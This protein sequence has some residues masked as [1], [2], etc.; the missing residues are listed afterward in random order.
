MLNDFVSSTELPWRPVYSQ[1]GSASPAEVTFDSLEYWIVAATVFFTVT[2]YVF[3]NYLNQRQLLAFEKTEFPKQLETTVDGIDKESAVAKKKDDDDSKKN[4]TKDDDAKK[5]NDD[6][7][8]PDRNAPL[9]PQLR[10][11]FAKAQSYGL[12]RI[13]FGMITDL[14]NLVE[15]VGFLLLGFLPYSWDL[16]ARIGRDNPVYQTESEIGVSLIFVL[17]TTLFGMVTSLPFELY[18]TFRIEKK[19]GFNKMTLSLFFSDKIKGLILS[20][21]IGGPF[22]AL[23]LKIIEWGG[24]RFYIYVWAFTVVFSLFMM[25]IVP[26]FIMPLFNKYD[27]LP[28]G[29]LKTRIYAL[30]EKLKF[31]LTKLF[32]M[33][34]SKRSAHSNAFMFGFG[35]NKRVVLYDTLMQQVTNDELLAILGHELGHWKLKH[36]LTNLFVTQTYTGAMFYCF[37]L[38]FTNNDLFAAFG[39]A[40]DDRAPTII[41]LLLFTQTIWAPVDKALSFALT[42]FSRRNE[43]QAD[44]FSVDLGM[45]A[46]LRSGLCKIHLENLGA[47]CTDPLYSAYHH[48]H[49]PLVER[50]ERMNEDDA[51]RVK[52]QN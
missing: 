25:T 32:V 36:T 9:L 7:D 44:R 27:P 43:F 40:R 24:E 28:E 29:D 20:M 38:F 15:G 14:Y 18:S 4:E 39:F 26:V 22:L 41:A 52:K 10:T 17:T 47:M 46:G 3:E 48:S 2:V 19:H 33:D 30:A 6:G 50:L 5:E 23:F 12:D 21:V 1:D 35:K 45:G 16:S 37:S 51:R 34:G 13:S 42:V 49:P 31:P 11:K 8:K